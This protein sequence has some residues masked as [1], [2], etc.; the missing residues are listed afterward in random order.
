MEDMNKSFSSQDLQIIRKLFEEAIK[1]ERESEE[2]FLIIAAD[3]GEKAVVKD[4]YRHSRATL[5]ILR[6]K[7]VKELFNA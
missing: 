1:S 7:L 5:A 4:K 6:S 2:V 3:D